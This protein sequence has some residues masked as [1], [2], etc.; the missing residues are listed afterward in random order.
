M[1]YEALVD[2]IKDIA[3]QAVQ[4]NKPMEVRF[5]TVISVDDEEEGTIFQCKLSQKLTL[6]AAYFIF[7]NGSS[8][9]YQKVGQK[10]ILLS[11]AGGQR[12]VILTDPRYQYYMM[13]DEIDD[14][15]TN[16]LLAYETRVNELIDVK[17]LAYEARVRE[18]ID[19]K[20]QSFETRVNQ[21]IEEAFTRHSSTS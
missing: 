6:T 20:L 13:H 19:E 1:K 10:L 7:P 11:N 3:L 12:F 21:L 18:L 2:V 15:I 14:L 5:G 16:R 4:S 8:K 17:L 9:E